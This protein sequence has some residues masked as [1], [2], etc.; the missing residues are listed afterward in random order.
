MA[1]ILWLWMTYTCFVRYNVPLYSML[2]KLLAAFGTKN[3]LVGCKKGNFEAAQAYS[4]IVNTALSV[5]FLVF[6][7]TL[8]WETRASQRAHAVVVEI[9]DSLIAKLKFLT[10]P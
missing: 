7:D 8:S 3:M 1:V 4:T 9:F 5:V 2:G 10:T 6:A